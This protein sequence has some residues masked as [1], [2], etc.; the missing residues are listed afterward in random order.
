MASKQ[1][2]YNLFTKQQ[3]KDWKNLHINID[4]Y[5][6]KW[7]DGYF[8]DLK[9]KLDFFEKNDLNQI[10]DHYKVN[11][12]DKQPLKSNLYEDIKA[13][14]DLYCVITFAFE[15][16]P[17]VISQLLGIP[18]I[19]NK[20]DKR[21]VINAV[22]KHHVDG[23]LPGLFLRLLK[24]KSGAG[25]YNFKFNSALKDR[26][27]K[28]IKGIM[29]PMVSLLKR[30]D[31]KKKIYYFRQSFKVKEKWIFLL[32]KETVDFL[33]PAIPDN[34]R[35]LKG[36]YIFVTIT[37]EDNGLEINTRSKVIAYQIR[38]Y[39]SRKVENQLYYNRKTSTYNPKKFF[40]SILDTDGTDEKTDLK[41][42]DV[43]FRTS[44]IDSSLTITD[45]NHK[46]SIIV[47]LK[48]L[49]D[50][51]L[52]KLE[53]FSEFQYM[54]FY[55]RGLQF[56]VNIELNKWGSYRIHLLDK[57]KPV[58]ELYDF[59]RDY[60]TAYN[61]P[62]DTYLENVDSKV[63]ERRIARQILNKRTL[64]AG[65]PETAE[66]VLLQLI[67]QKILVKPTKT[68]KRKCTNKTC[69][70]YTWEPGDCPICGNELHIEGD[71]IDLKINKKGVYQFVTNLL[72]ANKDFSVVK[73][74]KQIKSSKF[75][76]IDF[77]DKK[78]NPL[79]IYISYGNVPEKI[80]NYYQ[81]TGN[82]LMIILL[83]FKGALQKDILEHSFECVDITDLFA[84]RNDQA[85]INKRF[86]E[87]VMMQKRKW[88][89]KLVKKG[90]ESFQS[91]SNKSDDYTDQDF[92]KDIYNMLHEMF[93]VGDRL[94]GKFTGIAAPD[95]IV[96]IHNGS[97]PQQRY[98]L[99]WDCKYSIASKG[100]QL[101]D[102]ATKHR[103]YINDLKKN[104]K[105][106]FFGGLKT[107]A[108]ISQNMD[109]SKYKTFYFKLINRFRWK[110]NVVYFGENHLLK[111]YK[112]YKDNSETLLINPSGFYKPLHRLLSKIHKRDTVPFPKITNRRLG[113]FFDEIEAKYTGKNLKFEFDRSEF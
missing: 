4:S 84:Y 14:I 111:I 24:H 63:D 25:H 87:F 50:K 42:V 22:F 90:L 74:T 39:L 59:K 15:H 93:I 38:N 10:L 29:R 5:C 46:N 83:K 48:T 21:Q 92:E 113:K 47:Q 76:I 81:E 18:I 70:K 53:D 19:R 68:S 27:F 95:G 52:I 89:E 51:G 28:K 80:I 64:E 35:V 79:S 37:P 96:S 12:D 66:D 112:F 65:L 72:K 78:G 99:T 94:G 86:R 11:I 1:L 82:P 88:H 9:K 40:N 56:K 44:E 6:D 16:N 108:I 110:G 100:Y 102:K 45:I 26:D 61:V 57:S 54:T 55:Y 20:I 62:F 71:Y 33:V 67:K 101:A 109:F 31:K 30:Y 13:C 58:E 23:N 77:I 104:D 85:T 105:V 17:K 103:K 73:T 106:L 34:A 75:D 36:D 3:R 97:T 69:R 41:L 91:I 7:D 60:E 98:C 43:K 2:K 32:L 8:D 49:K 107:Y